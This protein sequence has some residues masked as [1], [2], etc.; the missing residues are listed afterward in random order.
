MTVAYTYDSNGNRLT[1]PGLVTP[2]TY[3]DQDRLRAYGSSNYAYTAHGEV[4]SKRTGASITTYQYDVLG[5]L[6]RVTLPGGPVVGYVLNGQNRRIGK[7]FE[8]WL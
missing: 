8:I 2:P 4:A 5:N 7:K 1:G 6:T 3:D